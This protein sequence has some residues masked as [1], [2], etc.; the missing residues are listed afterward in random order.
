MSI[1][2][3]KM[4]GLG[5]DFVVIDAR[6]SGLQLTTAQLVAMANR[7]TGVGCD[8]F[9]LMYPS[10]KADIRVEMFNA[11]GSSL[12]ACGNASRCIAALMMAETGRPAVTI[13][14]V[15]GVIN[16][17]AADHDRITVDMGP[18]SLLWRDIPLTEAC[19]TQHLPISAGPLRDGVAVNVGNPHA[20]F[21]VDD[22]QAIDLHMLGPQLEHHPLFPDRANIEAVQ[23][24]APDK[25]LMR[26]WERGTGLTQACG[27]GACATVVAAFTRGLAARKAEVVM[28]GGSL[29]IEYAENHHVLMTGDWAQSFTGEWEL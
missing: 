23:V 29:E 25:L 18:A 5:N 22:V 19:D 8:Q 10:D 15:V 3:R 21:F 20:V 1:F 16:A 4:H 24:V 17:S 9:V 6:A 27:S 14:T 13:E 26:V 12:R 28:P 11:D 2:F 7:R